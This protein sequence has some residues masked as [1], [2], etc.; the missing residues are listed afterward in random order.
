MMY[1]LGVDI[2]SIFVALVAF[3]RDAMVFVSADCDDPGTPRHGQRKVS[4]SGIGFPVGAVISFHCDKT[5]QLN[6]TKKI[7]CNSHNRWSGKVPKCLSQITECSLPLPTFSHAHITSNPVKITLGQSVKY[8]C[9]RG[10]IADGQSTSILCDK[11]PS[12]Q[13]VKWTGNFT[14]RKKTCGPP[15]STPHGNYT[16]RVYDVTGGYANYSCH[17]GYAFL[18]KQHTGPI[19]IRC[20]E[21]DGDWEE[22]PTCVKTCNSTELRLENGQKHSSQEGQ[23]YVQGVVVTFSCRNLYSLKEGS[24][25]RRCLENGHWDGHQPVCV[26]SKCEHFEEV[27]QYGTATSNASDVNS[28]VPLYTMI[29]YQCHVG[30]MLVGDRTRQCLPSGDW[31]TNSIPTCNKSKLTCDPPPPVD[32]TTGR[33]FPFSGTYQL[34]AKVHYECYGSLVLWGP[35]HI[36]C[37]TPDD[38]I[39][40]IWLPPEGTPEC[41]SKAVRDER[42]RRYWKRPSWCDRFTDIIT[43]TVE[44]TSAVSMNGGELDKM[45]IVVATAGSTL[46]ALVIFLTALVC[47]RRFHRTRRFRHLALRN[48]RCSDDDRVAIIAA[49][50][51]DVHF[52]LPSYDE[53][54]NQVQNRPPPSFESVV[55]DGQDSREPTDR[56]TTGHDP[57]NRAGRNS[58]PNWTGNGAAVGSNPASNTRD[59][60]QRS[61]NDQPIDIVRTPNSPS[62]NLSTSSSEDDLVPRDTRPLLDGR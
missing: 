49:Y 31:S 34:N 61:A 46:G 51:G 40:A 57:G 21:Q 41:I 43:P 4:S 9:D 12:S 22:A 20:Y 15:P 11:D 56:N 47:F 38:G 17:P 26:R 45:T 2:W 52:V 8:A 42:C 1:R 48:R 58:T 3:G 62:G 27:F 50:T 24:T 25:Q 32:A 19:R 6:G 36:T 53:A 10:Y 14:C 44:L 60:S 13:G 37:T 18:G 55:P 33:Y 59:S 35:E 16:F 30:Y 5:Y 54:I 39:T 29:T 7:E 28:S 23:I